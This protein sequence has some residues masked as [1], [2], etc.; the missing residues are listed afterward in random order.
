MFNRCLLFISCILF[1][2]LSLFSRADSLALHKKLQQAVT[3][4]QKADALIN[5]SKYYLTKDLDKAMELVNSAKAFSEKAKY[6]EGIANAFGIEGE[7]NY[8]LS[9]YSLAKSNFIE[10]LSHYDKNKQS[11]GMAE[12]YE[13]LGKVAY[14]TDEL[15]A[16][17]T[18]YSEA[19]TIFEKNNYKDGLAGLYINLGLLYEDTRNEPQAIEFYNKAM[20]LA[21]ETNDI[22]SEA[23]C[24]TNLGNIY[25]NQG[26]YKK[27]IE[28]LEISLELKRKVGN[29][30]G[31]GTSLNNLGAIYYGM[32]DTNRALQHFQEAYQIY[33]EMGDKKSSFPSCN[34][35]GSIYYDKKDYPKAKEYYDK[36]HEL[37]IE[38]NSLSKK[39]LCLENLTLLHRDMG[40]Y[41]KAVDY[42][43][44]CWS[45]K[46]TLYN[47]D[48]AEITA[49]MQ[50]KFASEKKQQENELLNLKVKS[51]SFIKTIFIIAASILCVLVFFVFRGLKQKQKVN[52]ALEEKNKIIEEQKQTV[53]NQKHIVEEQNKDITDS[54]RYAERIQSAILPPEKQWQSLLPQSFVFYKPKDILSGD[55]YW[56]EQKGDLV[57]VAA[58]DCTGH[59]VPG[60]LISIVNYNLL[61][62]AVLEKDLNDPADILNY[63]NNQL[64]VALHQTYQ[65]SSVKD[66]M[67]IS[68][69]VLNT[70]TLELNYAGAN[71]P[72]YLIKDDELL[73]ISADKFPVGAFVE[74]QIQTFTSKTIQLHRNDLVYLFSDGYADQFGGEKGKKFKYKQLKDILEENKQL[75]MEEQS[76]ILA[77]RF[78]SWKGMLEQVDDVLIIGIRV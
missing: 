61:N 67:D 71:N 29:K 39:I 49:E 35:I 57:F 18:H 72:I 1:A 42:S 31:E 21:K 78:E 23:S 74:E 24:Y 40:D 37:A 52:I 8:L 7:I 75:P 55:F 66:G 27:A 4:E 47:K 60:A 12:A 41:K 51:E 30:K 53:E 65:E 32:Q 69:C 54:I 2:G 10:A 16:A 48:Q 46:D 50:T 15:D 6:E 59:G 9:E 11:N 36:A 3:N 58:A 56:I 20:V 33:M 28:Y 44:E 77:D 34:N 63:V 17:L 19:L 22:V 70:K 62:K 68:L 14:K 43:V 45:L 25:S 5:L 64:I 73:Q 76:A 26:N 38:L 13:G